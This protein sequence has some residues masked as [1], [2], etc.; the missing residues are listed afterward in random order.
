MAEF[1]QIFSTLLFFL[2]YYKYNIYTA[3]LCLSILSIIQVL[4]GYFFEK[5]KTSMNQSSLIMLALFGFATWYFANPRF[6]QWKIT[7][8]NIGFAM[9]IFGYRHFNREAF[10]TSTFKSSNMTIP[11]Q[12]GINADNMLALFFVVTGIVNIWVFSHYSEST[13]VL[14]K[15]SII[16]INIAYLIIITTYLSRFVK[17]IENYEEN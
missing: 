8:A 10:F 4:A 16:F 2:V 6:I 12:A 11:N 5:A 3:S 1:L 14:F 9:F 7:I 13:W 15:T 17:P